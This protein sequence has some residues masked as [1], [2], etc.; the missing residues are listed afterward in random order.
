MASFQKVNNKW[1]AQINLQGVRRSRTFKTKAEATRWAK[2]FEKEI[3]TH[4]TPPTDISFEQL[5]TEYARKVTPIKRGGMAELRRIQALCKEPPFQNIKLRDVHRRLIQDWVDSKIGSISQN[6]HRP[7]KSSTVARYLT[8][9]KAVFNKA[10]DWEYIEVSPCRGVRCK[11]MEDHRERVATE[12]EIEK[13]KLVA[14]W[15]ESEPPRLISQRVA[16]AFVF[17]CFTGMRVGEI[18]AMERSWIVDSVIHIPREDT[19]T[20]HGRSLAVPVRAMKI[21][22][23]VLKLN[24]KHRIFGLKPQQHDAIFRHI[25]NMAGL[26]PVYD[27][28]GNCIK[29]GLNFHDSR[30]TF[31]TWAASPGPDG[32]PRLDVMS[33]ARQTGHR[34]LRFLMHYYRKRPEEMLDRLNS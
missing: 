31:C 2:E 1:R 7:I 5:L 17:A 28:K 34:N 23:Q 20:Y 9:L 12:E 14:L 6:S 11:V 26:G 3:F 18:I 10:V 32:A 21:L 15:N 19:K 8:V 24:N 4:G 30:A 22:Q 16:A 33:L 13:I 27:S 25:R 29:E